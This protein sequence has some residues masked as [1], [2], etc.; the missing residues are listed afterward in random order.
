MIVVEHPEDTL[1]VDGGSLK[2]CEHDLQK[3]Q[4][5]CHIGR[6]LLSTNKH[7]DGRNKLILASPKLTSVSKGITDFPIM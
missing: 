6:R 5:Y 3:P 4:N 1:K 7:L 2:I